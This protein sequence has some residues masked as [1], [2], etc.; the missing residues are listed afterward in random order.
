METDAKVRLL[1]TNDDWRERYDDLVKS[2]LLTGMLFWSD[3]KPSL[4]ATQAYLN[5]LQQSSKE[6]GLTAQQRAAAVLRK[7]R[8]VTDGS[9]EVKFRLTTEIIQSIYTNL[10]KIK[11]LHDDFVGTKMLTEKDFW[12][13]FCTSKTFGKELGVGEEF[14]G[15]EGN[16][17][18]R[19]YEDVEPEKQ[20]DSNDKYDPEVEFKTIDSNLDITRNDDNEYYVREPGSKKAVTASIKQLNAASSKALHASSSGLP[21]SIEDVSDMVHLNAQSVETLESNH[22]SESFNQILN[23]RQDNIAIETY[24]PQVITNLRLLPFPSFQEHVLGIKPSSS[25]FVT[26]S[27]A[28]FTENRLDIVKRFY[29]NVLQVLRIFWRL[30]NGPDRTLSVQLCMSALDSLQNAYNSHSWPT[31]QKNKADILLSNVFKCVC[32]AREKATVHK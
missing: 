8:G 10:P 16:I 12:T 9:G 22:Q 30:P 24:D 21:I 26:I 17:I 20:D 19:A 28:D 27:E 3:K 4:D 1:Q 11:Q 25:S 13:Q 23:T 7:I 15:K 18:D 2:G 14:T 29:K 5:M 31:E 6:H 32:V